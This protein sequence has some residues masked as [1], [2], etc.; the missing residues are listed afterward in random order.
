MAAR[1]TRQDAKT[2]L[3]AL[4]KMDEWINSHLGEMN[5]KDFNIDLEHLDDHIANVREALRSLL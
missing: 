4:D 2:H 3:K 1:P 5:T